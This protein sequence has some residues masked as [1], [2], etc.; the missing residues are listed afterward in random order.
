MTCLRK[1]CELNYSALVR[2]LIHELGVNPN[3]LDSGTGLDVRYR[4]PI[5]R[6][7]DVQCD[8]SFVLVLL[9]RVMVVTGVFLFADHSA[10]DVCVSWGHRVCCRVAASS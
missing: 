8:R 2:V 10:G 4:C 6:V 3:G 9:G 5:T 1:A 7:D